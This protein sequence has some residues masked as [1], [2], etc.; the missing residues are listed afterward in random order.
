[1]QLNLSFLEVPGPTQHLW[2]SLDHEQRQDVLD[3]LSRLIATAA[4]AIEGNGEDG[5]DNDD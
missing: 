5:E 3:R 2:E 1:V 4:L